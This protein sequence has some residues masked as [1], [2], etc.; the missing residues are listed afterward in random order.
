MSGASFRGA[1]GSVGRGSA[2]ELPAAGAQGGDHAAVDEQVG[3]G[4]EAGVGA[5]EEGGG[6][7]H[8]VGGADPAGGGDLDHLLVALG[9][10][11]GHLVAGQRGEDDAGADAVDPGAAVAPGNGGGLHAQVFG[12]LGDGVRG[13]G[14]RHRVRPEDGQGQQ[15]VGGRE[16]QRVRRLR[17]Q[18][19]GGVG[20]PA[21]G[22]GAGGPRGG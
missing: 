15:L 21:G 16:S 4:D 3:A 22:V 9:A 5:E 19:R 7:G 2:A 17:V 10:R 1:G 12:L 20:G 18:R 11:A 6:G 13:T 8:L 14:G